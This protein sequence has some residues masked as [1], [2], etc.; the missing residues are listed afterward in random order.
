MP[1]ETRKTASRTL[2]SGIPASSSAASSGVSGPRSI[3]S[4]RPS[5]SA[6]ASADSRNAGRRR[7]PER[8]REQHRPVGRAAQQRG[9]D[10]ERRLVGPVQ[11]VEREQQRAAD[12]EPVEQLLHRAVRAVALGLQRAVRHRGAVERRGRSPPARRAARRRRARACAG[13]ATRGGR[14]ARRRAR[15]TAARARTPPR[16]PA[17]TSHPRSPASA[18]SRSITLV[19]PIP[20]SPTTARKPGPPAATASSARSSAASSRPR[21]TRSSAVALIR[22]G[23]APAPPARARRA[24]PAPSTPAL[25][26]AGFA[27]AA[28]VRAASSGPSS[29][30]AAVGVDVGREPRRLRLRPTPSTHGMR[31]WTGAQTRVRGRSSG[32]S[33]TRSA[34][35][36]RGPRATARRTRTA[37]R[38]RPCSG[39]ATRSPFGRS[40]RS[41][42]YQPSATTRQRCAASPTSGANSRLSS[43]DSARALIG[44]G[45]ARSLRAHGGIEPPAQRARLARRAATASTGSVGQTLKRPSV[46]PGTADSRT[47]K[48]SAI[49]PRIDLRGG[50]AAAHGA[51]SY[52]A[53]QI[54][55]GVRA[56]VP[57]HVGETV[58][59]RR[60]RSGMIRR[61]LLLP[62]ELPQMPD[63]IARTYLS[64]RR[65]LRLRP[66]P[67]QFARARRRPV[68]ALAQR[69]DASAPRGCATPASCTCSSTPSAAAA[70]AASTC[71]R[72]RMD[73]AELERRLAGWADVC[74]REGSLEWLL[75]RVQDLAARRRARARPAR[76]FRRGRPGRCASAGR[77]GR[78]SAYWTA[79]AAACAGSRGG[80]ASRGSSASPVQ[81]KCTRVSPPLRAARAV[82]RPRRACRRA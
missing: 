15:R 37:R 41:H 43:S 31:S 22:A 24:A 80:I 60:P 42:S 53:R 9:D 79:N 5:R 10:L 81:R 7:R 17:S 14:R 19:L 23:A 57:P 68:L 2:G 13:R 72:R 78:V 64:P 44:S 76:R 12:G 29:S 66:C 28:A 32:S 21:P 61:S 25:L 40:G 35:R 11:V 55:A 30:S 18:D 45:P 58:P 75:A 1:P 63:P 71:S 38:R 82:A 50:V 67:P 16:G 34:R 48:R 47:P 54:A 65:V 8:A 20:G 70:A 77:R 69:P 33:P 52:A 3:R 62:K 4:A 39:T 59:D 51:R 74:G 26:T 56:T 49:R 6:A 36:R 73:E 27:G 46:S